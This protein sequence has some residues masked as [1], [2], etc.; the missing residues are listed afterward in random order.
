MSI[1]N[2]KT[3]QER[4]DD[5]EAQQEY[6]NKQ[7]QKAEQ[8]IILNKKIKTMFSSL[9]NTADGQWVLNYLKSRYLDTP[10]S[11]SEIASKPTAMYDIGF[12]QGQ[13]NLIKSIELI[14]KDDDG[15]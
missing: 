4:K 6:I 9:F 3:K 8:L 15:R 1:D 12:N 10:I 14:I 11:T 13:Y 2:Y 7:K 5:Q